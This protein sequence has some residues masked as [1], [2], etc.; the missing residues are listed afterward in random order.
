M[1]SEGEKKEATGDMTSDYQPLDLSPYCNAGI[2]SF[3][4][5]EIDRQLIGAQSFHGLPFCIGGSQPDPARCFIGL[6]RD[7]GDT[8]GVRIA[9]GASA[10]RLIFAHA[11]LDKQ[12]LSEG[13]VPGREV[14]RYVIRLADGQEISVPVRERFEVACVPT[15]WGHPPFLA[16]PDQKDDLWPRHEG[17]WNDFGSHRFEVIQGAARAYY[18]WAWENPR[19]DRRI[20]SVTVV[21]CGWKFILAGITLGRRDEPP[22]PRTGPREV[23]IRLP[24]QEDAGAQTRR[25]GPFDLEVEVDRGVA[26]HAHPL[27]ASTPEE[28]LAHPVKGC[29]EPLPDNPTSAYVEIAAI[30]SATVSVKNAGEEIGRV[31]WGTLEDHGRVELP[32]V[33]LEIADRGRNWVHITVQDEATGKPLPCRV[34]FRSP[35][36]IP[37][38]PCGHHNN[39]SVAQSYMT[40]VGGDFCPGGGAVTYAYIDG[41][42]QGWLPRG[43]VLVDV[44][45]G[46]EYEPLRTRV[47]IAPGQ[48]D[49]VLKLR[50]WIDQNAGGWYSGDT[51]V[52][53]LGAQGAHRE[54]Q[55]EDLNFINLMATQLGHLFCNTEDFIGGP[56]ASNGGRTLVWV[57]QENRQHLLGHLS[58]LGLRRPV[59][60]WCTGGPAEAEIGG[61]L[62]ETMSAWADACHAQDGLVIIP[63][64]P[65]PNGE[66][67]ALIAT[68]R[69]DAVELV[70][71]GH[72]QH[73]CRYHH[74]EYY[75]YLNG[76]YRL[77]LVGGT[78]K[79]SAGVAVGQVRTYAQVSPQEPFGFESWFKAIRA[80]RTFMTTGP[81]IR[82]RVDGR[83]IGDMLELP[84]NGGTVEVEAQAES[85]F[86]IFVLQIV[87]EGKVVASTQD[88]RGARR[89]ELRAKLKID[90]H[91]WLAARCGGPDYGS[92]PPGFDN[93]R[94]GIF[95]HT[96]PIYVAVGGPWWMFSED[97]AQYM[98]TLID[99]SLEYVRH[100]ARY[101]P[102]Q[103]VTHHHGH[104]DHLAYLEQPFHQARQAIARARRHGEA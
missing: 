57:S 48:R 89:L 104:E 7:T 79:M 37:Y 95:A 50:R 71:Q 40:D 68:G 3:P 72:D 34:H 97:A 6:G 35:D 5:A 55:G 20:E 4:E 101:W 80:G 16:H 54:A 103:R 56:T 10:R 41:T 25:P 1:P 23:V 81:M 86:P 43:E 44:I 18:L 69:G 42:C 31:E 58:L 74:N 73:Q 22:F 24:R 63:H 83:E 17:R 12:R 45:R 53:I 21:P 49:L 91:T 46:F 92:L 90:R 33:H 52:H 102:A 51:H 96:S 100:K 38:Q 93:R 62:Q 27:P 88:A 84:G 75:R 94:R 59:M 30:P 11:L 26:G 64:L 65:A 98:L 29:G 66:T 32:R 14:A 99:G 78:D 39:V 19:P 70:G 85:I 15:D 13:G 2:G 87:R 8:E 61:T 60:P 76:G 47:N 67:A 28:F 36:G 77:P 9:V 82:L